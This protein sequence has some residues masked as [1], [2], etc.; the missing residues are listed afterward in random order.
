M[1][2]GKGKAK[3][4]APAKAWREKET[5]PNML[6]EVKVRHVCSREGNEG[7]Q[8][9]RLGQRQDPITSVLG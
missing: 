3:E 2:E 9:K 4:M 7:G 6:Q 8:E 1:E 5:K